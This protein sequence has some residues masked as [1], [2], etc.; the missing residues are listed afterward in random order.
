MCYLFN[1]IIKNYEGR[2]FV[3]PS[4]DRIVEGGIT[5]LAV[6]LNDE[7]LPEIPND[8]SAV[9]IVVQP[10][11]CMPQEDI[12]GNVKEN[13]KLI[14]IETPTNPLLKV[15][16]LNAVKSIAK[17]HNIIFG[18]D[19]TFSTP[20]LLRPLEFGADIT[21]HSTTKYISGHNQIIGGAIITNNKK[22]WISIFLYI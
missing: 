18:V 11:D 8:I 5:H 17:K 6:I 7:T 13:T 16:D 3:L 21:M 19:S 9:P 10:R 4:S 2:K 15:T 1:H 12:M 22:N 20:A 14:W